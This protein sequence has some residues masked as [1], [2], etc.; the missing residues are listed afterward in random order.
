MPTKTLLTEEEYLRTSFDDRAPDY[1]DGELVERGLPNNSHSRTQ[2]KSVFL[3]S[4]LGEQLPIYP[5]PELRLR[6]AP[7]KYRIA[8]LVVYAHQEPVDELPEQLPLVVIEI[9][10]PDDRH[11]ELMKK[12]EEYRTWGVPYIWLA[13]PALGR[14]YAYRDGSLIPVAVLELPEFGIR[15]PAQEVLP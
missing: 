11:D 7:G 14:T 13:D 4:K 10:S 8:D 1:V 12:L 15:I 3:F 9:V 6:V 5:R 2:Q